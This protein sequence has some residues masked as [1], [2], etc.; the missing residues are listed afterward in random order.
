MEY[1][2]CI[3][4]GSNVTDIMKLPCV[5][6]C[7]KDCNSDLVYLLYDWDDHGC[8]V[9]CRRGDWLCEGTDGKWY[10]LTDKEYGEKEAC[11]SYCDAG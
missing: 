2:Q 10:K 6:S 9:E 3:Q 5:F 7:H 11:A 4:I 1:S 8:Y